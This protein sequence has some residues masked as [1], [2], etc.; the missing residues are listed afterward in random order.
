[1]GVGGWGETHLASYIWY[2][3]YL[4]HCQFCMLQGLRG[5]KWINSYQIE[6]MKSVF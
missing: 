4:V 6:K 2:T 3:E 1:M 5:E